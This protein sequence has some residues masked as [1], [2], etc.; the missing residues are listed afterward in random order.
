MV[1]HSQQ[2]AQE[3]HYKAFSHFREWVNG[4]W[5]LTVEL[6]NWF[7]QLNLCFICVNE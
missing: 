4:A 5:Q 3:R 1:L 2:T 7:W 6:V